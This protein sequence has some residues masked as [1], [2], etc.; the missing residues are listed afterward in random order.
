MDKSGNCTQAKLNGKYSTLRSGMYDFKQIAM[1]R[2]AIVGFLL[3]ST[4]VF[5][6]WGGQAKCCIFE[7]F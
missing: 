4:G 5:V 6:F 2:A 7:W 3:F 1:W